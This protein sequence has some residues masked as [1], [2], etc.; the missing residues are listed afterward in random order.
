MCARISLAGGT[1]SACD[2]LQFVLARV[3]VALGGAFVIVER[4]ARGDHVHQRET[5]VRDGGLE[6]RHEL[7]LVARKAARHE[8]RADAER[9]HHRIDRRHA[10]RLAALALRADVGRS[11]ELALGQAIDAVVLDHVQHLHIAA[12]GVAQVAEA[13]GERIA[14]AGDADVSQFAI[15]RVG[16]G[17]DRRHASVRGVEAVRAVDE[18]GRRLRRAADAAQLGDHVRLRST[19]P[20]ARGRAR[21]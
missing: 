21:R 20:T 17:G 16:A 7:F 3:Q 15:G 19:A 8:R 4:H 5:A 11:R 6:D 2:G 1:K 12:D 10:V 9:Q 14:V 18:I 13:D